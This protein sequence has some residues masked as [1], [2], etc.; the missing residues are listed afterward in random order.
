MLAAILTATLALGAGDV[1]LLQFTSPYCP[2][3]QTMAP[4]IERLTASGV[5]VQ[6]IDV[7]AREDLARQFRI[8]ALPTTIVVQHGREVERAEGAVAFDRIVAMVQRASHEAPANPIATLASATAP[9]IPPRDFAASNL[10]PTDLRPQTLQ[11]NPQQVAYAATVRLKVLDGQGHGVGTGTIIDRHGEEALVM[12]CAHIFRTSQGKGEI[13]VDLFAKPGTTVKGQLIDWDLHRDVALVAIRPGVE[14][15]PIPVA[16]PDYKSQVA[17]PVFSIGCNKGQDP[18]L[19]ESRIAA[20]NKFNGRPN[21]TV[22]GQPIDGRS[23]GG[24]FNAA[25]QLIGV[26]NAADAVDDVGVYASLP[27]VHWQL[28][29]IGQKRIYER[30]NEVAPP[31][32]LVAATAPSLPT[33]MPS[34]AMPTNSLAAAASPS[35][36]LAPALS[37]P[38]ALA[39]A[40]ALSDDLE[41]FC[42]VRR[43]SQPHL[44]PQSFPLDRL[45]PE[46]AARLAAQSNPAASLANERLSAAPANSGLIIRGQQ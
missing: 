42:V 11:P 43:K 39:P 32:T 35:P 46:I 25:G 37:L 5:P 45:P 16:G 27:A 12:T 13:H 31:T 1:E 10:R 15:T 41:V 36:T 33:Q 6:K 34:L 23:G 24:L 20:V 14:V 18:T 26:C 44:A 2:A 19:V 7:Q 4:I 38:P 40:P 8:K 29:K 21:V 28:D 9:A 30:P 3:C 17:E 22:K